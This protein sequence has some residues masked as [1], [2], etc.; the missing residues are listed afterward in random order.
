MRR[1]LAFGF[2]LIGLGVAAASLLGAL[3]GIWWGFDLLANFRLQYLIAALF[4]ALV[5][6]LVK[7]RTLALI[8]L[9]AA[10]FNGVLI[11]PLYIRSP[12]PAASNAE[13]EIISFNVQLSNPMRQI[14][15]ILG[16]EPDLV[17]LFES[18]R[19]AE[20]LL[21][22]SD[23]GY[24]VMS[25]IDDD[26]QFGIT[27][28]S[29]KPLDVERLTF[30][31]GGG[32]FVRVETNLGDAPIAVY[33]IHPPSPSNPFRATAR[34]RFLESAGEVAAAEELPVIVTGDFNSTPWSEGFRLVSSPADLVNSQEGFGYGGTWPAQLWP[35]LRIPLDHLIHSR[36]LTTVDREVGPTL[37]SDHRPI[38]VVVGP[39]G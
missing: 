17:F 3:G 19:A 30:G 6:A 25:G 16:H 7:R 29:R 23:V 24:N 27:V 4:A 14:D 12:V 36:D 5:L 35:I 31:D 37:T 18:S 10:I 28:L 8:V 33:G 20:E 39:A 2:G 22:E 32:G 15:W 1:I 21:R 38:R 9:A 26:R 13:I 34:D 11:A